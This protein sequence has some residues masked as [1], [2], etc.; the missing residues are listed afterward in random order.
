MF[1]KKSRSKQWAINAKCKKIFDI[2]HTD[3]SL[4]MFAKTD[5]IDNEW[6]VSSEVVDIIDQI[7]GMR[8]AS[9]YKMTTTERGGK[10]KQE[11][12]AKEFIHGIIIYGEDGMWK[13]DCGRR[14]F[15]MYSIDSETDSY[16][17]HAKKVEKAFDAGSSSSRQ[18][19]VSARMLIHA[20]YMLYAS[21]S[22]L[23]LTRK[24]EDKP[25]LF[26]ARFDQICNALTRIK[27]GFINAK[28]LGKKLGT[29]K[30]EWFRKITSDPK[31]G[32][33]LHKY[34]HMLM[35]TNT[36]FMNGM[37]SFIPTSCAGNLINCMGLDGFD[38]LIAFL[39]TNLFDVFPVTRHKSHL[40]IKKKN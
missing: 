27:C 20:G 40:T 26:A 5:D 1:S 36:R 28:D 7:A 21:P 6:R 17:L 2:F 3:I 30:H 32:G 8:K 34:Q 38:V 10:D 35:V 12:M 15:T 29:S 16:Y 23:P 13:A 4:E 25:R 9:S 39:A 18:S 37:A 11:R 33:E 14:L 22:T 19:D 31:T 24:K